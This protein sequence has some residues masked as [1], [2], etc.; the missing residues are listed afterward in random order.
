ML[1]PAQPRG[2]GRPCGD[3]ATGTETW[4]QGGRETCG[5]L[6]TSTLS[7]PGE[8]ASGAR[9]SPWQWSGP[10]CS[11]GRG[12]PVLT[13]KPRDSLQDRAHGCAPGQ[14]SSCV[15]GVP[16]LLESFPEPQAAVKV[17]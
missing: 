1:A 17:V 12:L 13:A 15:P 14:S 9:W 8:L 5:S 11:L 10:C 16:G 6:G 3:S 7:F 2:S 4:K